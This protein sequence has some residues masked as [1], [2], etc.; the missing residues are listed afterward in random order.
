[1]I[2]GQTLSLREL[3]GCALVFAAII[4]SQLPWRKWFGSRAIS[5]EAI[6]VLA[7]EIEAVQAEAIQSEI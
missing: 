7:A 3:F 2:L 1:V 5:S 6:P 4:S